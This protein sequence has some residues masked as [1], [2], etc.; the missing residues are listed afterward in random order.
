MTIVNRKRMKSIK[1][2]ISLKDP[3]ADSGDDK[4]RLLIPYRKAKLRLLFFLKGLIYI[5]LAVSIF[6]II[7]CAV[8]KEKFVRKPKSKSQSQRAIFSS[9][10]TVYPAHIRYNN[11]FI[12][13]RTWQGELILNIG[14]N[15]K[16]VLAC[17]ER[18][19]YNLKQMQELLKSPKQEEL[20][21]YVDELSDI[22]NEL[23]KAR[24]SEPRQKKLINQ[25][26]HHLQQVRA[27][28]GYQNM[29]DGNWIQPD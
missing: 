2:F 20:A 23:E 21:P 14:K 29:R 22:V 16:K 15:N 19:L 27:G 11:Y 7:G 8:L 26:K 6:N 5:L 10:D 12:Y 1:G 18:A 28:F 24:L 3:T 9:T 25:L 13:W 17:A 4:K